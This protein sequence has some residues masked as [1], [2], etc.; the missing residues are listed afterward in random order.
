MKA[1][2]SARTAREKVMLGLLAVL[3]AAY[4]LFAAVWQPLQAERSTL[5]RDIARYTNA[6]V[7]LDALANAGLGP[8]PA[9][10]GMPLPTLITTSAETYQLPI[11]R[12]LPTADAVEITLENAPFELVLTW[13][14]ALEQDH[15]LRI[16][17]LTI[18]RRPEPGLVATTLSVGR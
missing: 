2:W 3:L 17:A 5:M 16:I 11:S 8:A 15:G 1:F 6:S 7:A 13:I 10:I 9:T 18:T 4:A 14:L 12:L